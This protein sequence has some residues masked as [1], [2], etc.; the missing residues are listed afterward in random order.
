MR[1]EIQ[2]SVVRRRAYKAVAANLDRSA[3]LSKIPSPV[4]KNRAASRQLFQTMHEEARG[5]LTHQQRQSF[6]TTLTRRLLPEG[7]FASRG[8]SRSKLPEHFN[9]ND[10]SLSRTA[11]ARDDSAVAN[12]IKQRPKSS[13]EI[14]IKN[15]DSF[16]QSSLSGT[17]APMII[18][19]SLAQ[20]NNHDI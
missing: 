6:D 10:L 12:H 1:S 20:A 17:F 13:M 2:K 19:S 15:L 9:N 7:A 14:E 16:G 3:R 4:R 5:H 18:Q 11:S 8:R